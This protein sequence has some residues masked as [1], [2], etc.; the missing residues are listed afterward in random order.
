MR[1]AGEGPS[2]G[3][4]R[5]EM[6]RTAYP[7]TCSD[8]IADRRPWYSPL[9][10]TRGWPTRLSGLDGHAPCKARLADGALQWVAKL[11]EVCMN[12]SAISRSV[13]KCGSRRDSH[14]LGA[15]QQRSRCTER[16][17]SFA[18]LPDC[19]GG[20]GV[21]VHERSHLRVRISKTVLITN[22]SFFE[23]TCFL[24]NSGCE[25]SRS[26]RLFGERR[27]EISA[28]YIEYLPSIKGHDERICPEVV[29]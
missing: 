17:Q 11:R 26:R 24:T 16:A 25:I 15:N 18:Q 19:V 9:L 12:R 8:G 10:R 7:T 6:L 28:A 14:P 1:L 20:R 27:K 21:D 13:I 5:G 3:L 23:R 22:H 29:L 4:D 2:A